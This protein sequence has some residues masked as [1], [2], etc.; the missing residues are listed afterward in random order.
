MQRDALAAMRRILPRGPAGALVSIE[1]QTGFIRAMTTTLD[2]SRVKFDLAWQAHRQLGSAMKP[3]A[4]TA[5]VEEGAN[6]ATTYYDS[7]PLHLY[8]GPH[9]VPPTGM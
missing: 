5:A 2:W 8:L 3:F 7:M 1:P 6:P 4:L 9:A